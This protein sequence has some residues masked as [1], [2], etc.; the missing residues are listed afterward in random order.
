MK[1]IF[2]LLPWFTAI[3]LLFYLA[4]ASPHHGKPMPNPGTA[5]GLMTA[6]V[7]LI[8]LADF[9]N[10][11]HRSNWSKG[12]CLGLTALGFVYTG[13]WVALHA[14]LQD[15]APDR[16]ALIFRSGIGSFWALIGVGFAVAGYRA[17]RRI[18]PDNAPSSSPIPGVIKLRVAPFRWSGFFILLMGFWALLCGAGAIGIMMIAPNRG[19]I[20]DYRYWIA[21]V[22]LALMGPGFL[23]LIFI[24]N[25]KNRKKKTIILEWI[26]ATG[27]A[28]PG[29]LRGTLRITNCAEHLT[30]VK[31]RLSDA[32][33][34]ADFRRPI[35][36]EAL[37]SE[38]VMPVLSPEGDWKCQLEIS[39]PLPQEAA[40]YIPAGTGEAPSY[41]LYVF[42]DEP[43]LR[44][45]RFPVFIA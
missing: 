26:L 13:S 12:G 20:L 30:R 7:A 36:P 39:L 19:V 18:G 45:V 41:W 4:G 24:V 23:L 29:K 25:W 34:D 14:W 8:G 44:Q 35:L 22:V 1:R 3:Y 21:P 6:I 17:I 42:Y 11:T 16:E 5:A 32:A 33:M 10:S 9:L 31:I 2:Y 37:H 27:A 43:A 40:S 15:P 28:E 38:P